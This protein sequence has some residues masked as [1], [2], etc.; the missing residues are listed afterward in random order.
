MALPPL[1]P[2]LRDSIRNRLRLCLIC[3]QLKRWSR[4]F[5]NQRPEV[6]KRVHARHQ[7]IQEQLAPP[8]AVT[9]YQTCPL[10][11]SMTSRLI[12]PIRLPLAS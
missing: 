6:Y 2:E 3:R 7:L 11:F 10:T 8:N 9:A 4:G 1:D 5:H 12:V